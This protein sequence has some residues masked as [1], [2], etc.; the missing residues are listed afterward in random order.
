MWVNYV[1]PW[2][3]NSKA[4]HDPKDLAVVALNRMQLGAASEVVAGGDRS[5]QQ[6]MVILEAKPTISKMQNHLC[7]NDH[8]WK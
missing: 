7:H 4:T 2:A 3:L 6:G 5:Q 1:Y 8:S